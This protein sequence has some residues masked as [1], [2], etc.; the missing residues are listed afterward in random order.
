MKLDI[1]RLRANTTLSDPNAYK[2]AR[3]VAPDLP[4]VPGHRPYSSNK[5]VNKLWKTRPVPVAL[6]LMSIGCLGA[7]S[8]AIFLKPGNKNEIVNQTLG[9]MRIELEAYENFLKENS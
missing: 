4:P 9:K 2:Y 5:N 3:E 1:N 6:G 7:Y 8:L